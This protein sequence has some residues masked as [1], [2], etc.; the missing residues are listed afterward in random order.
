MARR[1]KDEAALQFIEEVTSN[2]DEEQ[3]KV[4]AQILS[5][6]EDTEYL[7]RYGVK[8][9]TDP[10]TF[11]SKVPVVAYED[12]QP[13]IQ[14]IVNGDFSPILC[15]QP[16]TDFLTSSGTSAGERKLLPTTAEEM[17]RRQL[18]YSLLMP[19]MNQY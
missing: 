19:V 16:I 11:K 6:N 14:R 2:C 3:R 13:D 4:L 17:D 8:G 9:C 12:I 5:R 7:K 10:E 18:L 15:A 1:E